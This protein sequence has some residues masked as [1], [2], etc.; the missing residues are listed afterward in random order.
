[1]EWYVYESSYA[2][3][4]GRDKIEYKTFNKVHELLSSKQ[5]AT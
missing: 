1:M 2:N 3:N 4:S 5:E